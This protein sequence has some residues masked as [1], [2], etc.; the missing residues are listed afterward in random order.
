MELNELISNKEFLVIAITDGTD[1]TDLHVRLR[2]RYNFMRNTTC[3]IDG[4]DLYYLLNMEYGV[5]TGF[6]LSE[7]QDYLD[8]TA[9]CYT[10]ATE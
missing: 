8:S 4:N 10:I 3:I 1:A 6:S 5:S 7:L 9:T 2:D